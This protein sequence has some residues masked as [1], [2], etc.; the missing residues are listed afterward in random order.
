MRGAV[1]L[2]LFVPAVLGG[3]LFTDSIEKQ[4]AA[5][6]K[7]DSSLAAVKQQSDDDACKEIYLNLRRGK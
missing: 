7:Q 5:I 4:E 6:V 1:L 3:G 2:A